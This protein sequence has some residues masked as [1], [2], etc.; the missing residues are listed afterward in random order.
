MKNQPVKKFAA[1]C[2]QAAVWKREIKQADGEGTR[3]AF[4][5]SLDKR[6]KNKEGQWQST[7]YL[8]TEDLPKARLLIDEAYRF[9]A[10][11]GENVGTAVASPL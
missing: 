7:N 9:L 4:S 2:L 3:E 5:V 6:Y 11:K 1:G 8:G 10:L